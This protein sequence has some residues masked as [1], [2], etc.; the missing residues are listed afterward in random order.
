MDNERRN[1][2]LEM[3]VEDD[4]LTISIGISTLCYA[5]QQELHDVSIHDEDT[6]IKDFLVELQQE[7]E[8]GSNSIHLAFDEAANRTVENGSMA[9]E[10]VEE[11]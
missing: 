1:H 3:K 6:F 8:E 4:V 11:N 2:P 7:D 9:V 5:V 10:I